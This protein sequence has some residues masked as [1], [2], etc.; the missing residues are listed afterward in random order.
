MK[1]QKLDIGKKTLQIEIDSLK[2]LKNNF[3][4]NFNKAV[5]TIVNC[6]GKVIVSGVGKSGAIGAKISSTLA[7]V[8]T[9]SFFIDANSCSH[10]NLGMIDNKDCLIVIS[11]S[12]MSTELK[13]I[14]Q[15][16]NRRKIT[17]IAIVSKKNSILYKAADIKILLP[18]VREADHNQIVPT[19]STII[20]LAI[21]DALA[22]ASMKFRKFDKLDFKKF[23]PGGSLSIQLKTVEDLMITG[24]KIPFINE[25]RN[26]KNALKIISEKKL[27]VLIIINKKK[28]IKGIITDGDIKRAVQK[29]HNLQKLTI[30]KI[31]T[32]KPICVDKNM[33]AAKALS[34]M[35]EKKITSLCVTNKMKKTIGLIHIHNILAGGIK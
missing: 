7:S 9:P 26:M 1:K 21:G 5:E 32:K 25:N 15:Y 27:G 6:K 28:Q 10:G 19:S 17:L 4:K 34:I 2:K 8:G 23:H 22:V 31:M 3:P 30:K 11:L 13:N 20:Q 35:N 16:S 18:E 12:G 24:K 29:N 14:I 33:L